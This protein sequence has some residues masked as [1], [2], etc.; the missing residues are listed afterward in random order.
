MKKKNLNEI[1][2]I[3]KAIKNKYGEE[4]IQ[5]PKSSWTPEKEDKYLEDLRTF[6]K[7]KDDKK[8]TKE[9]DGFLVKVRKNKKTNK[10]TCPV[11]SSYSFSGDDDL[12][13]TK[14][15][16]C[17]NCY[18]EYVEDREERWKSGWRPNN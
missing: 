13:M 2:K 6:Y 8:E 11:C 12:Y 7:N 18:I 1:A 17:F 3:E 9:I 5:N 10:R 14:F 15:G 4:A 16:C